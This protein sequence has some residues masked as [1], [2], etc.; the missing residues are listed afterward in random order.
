MKDEQIDII[1]KI[2][3]TVCKVICEI[4]K[5]LFQGVTFTIE[6][7]WETFNEKNLLKT[8]IL[9]IYRTKLYYNEVDWSYFKFVHTFFERGLEH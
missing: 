4:V 6:K 1:V 3:K 8:R 9:R 7:L 2:L 5:I